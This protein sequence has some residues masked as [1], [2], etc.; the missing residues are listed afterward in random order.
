MSND[1]DE[2]FKSFLWSICELWSSILIDNRY[3]ISSIY[4]MLDKKKKTISNMIM[5]R[6]DSLYLKRKE[7]NPP[8]I[9]SL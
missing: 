8:N 3:N 4:Y 5:K 1:D 6:K 2:T 7:L 9:T